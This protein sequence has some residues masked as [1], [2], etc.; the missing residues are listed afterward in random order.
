MK[1]G[2]LMAMR[3][4]KRKAPTSEKME[5]VTLAILI[6]AIVFAMNVAL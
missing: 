5:S 1:Y 4:I 2:N 3:T 6:A